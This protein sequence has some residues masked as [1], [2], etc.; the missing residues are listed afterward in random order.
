MRDDRERECE[1]CG[2]GIYPGDT[3]YLD[4]DSFAICEDCVENMTAF[5]IV[6]ALGFDKKTETRSEGSWY[7]A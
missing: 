2:A 4:K 6:D 7:D 1:L 3:F 5:E